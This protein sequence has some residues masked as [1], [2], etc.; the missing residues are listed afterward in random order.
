MKVLDFFFKSINFRHLLLRSRKRSLSHP[1]KTHSR[2]GFRREF[3][4]VTEKLI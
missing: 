3:E 4:V 1:S 2:L